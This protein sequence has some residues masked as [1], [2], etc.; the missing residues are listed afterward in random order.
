MRKLL[1]ISTFLASQLFAVECTEK[2][3]SPVFTDKNE[4]RYMPSHYMTTDNSFVVTDKQ[5]IVYD[6]SNQK[7]KVWIINQTK[8]A[9]YKG[10][11]ILKVYRE[12]NLKNNQVRV[13]EAISY[14][15]NGM[16]LDGSQEGESNWERIIPES[17]NEFVLNSLKRYLNIK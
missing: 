9:K 2:Q 7:I 11:A 13:I 4:I 14:E 10:Q 3:Y 15:C 5:S 6:K 16:P 1:L 8:S 12:F 17:G